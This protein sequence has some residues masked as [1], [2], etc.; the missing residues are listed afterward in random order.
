[1]EAPTTPPA[2]P[3]V[4]GKR[5][6]Q[7]RHSQAGGPRLQL[8]LELLV[9]PPLR[10]HLGRERI[11]R[12]RC[13]APPGL[14]QLAAGPNN[15]LPR[16]TQ[17]RL[18]GSAPH[19]SHAHP[20]ASA[21]PTWSASLVGA[22]ATTLRLYLPLRSHDRCSTRVGGTDPYLTGGHRAAA[23][24][25]CCAPEVDASPPLALR[26]RSCS[27]RSTS[28]LFRSTRLV[29]LRKPLLPL[30][31]CCGPGLPRCCCCWRRRPSS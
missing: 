1:M 31:P 12:G 11:L 10:R 3:A 8:R 18:A 4:E 25:R 30:P 19:P 15:T 13:A 9:P 16:P 28:M 24:G 5:S 22:A 14:Q 6:G 29:R 2:A 17:V 20:R 27:D 7:A 23:A 26:A 21:P